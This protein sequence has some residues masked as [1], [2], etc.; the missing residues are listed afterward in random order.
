MIIS[1]FVGGLV[2]AI[3]GRLAGARAG[4]L[5]LLLGLPGA[6]VGYILFQYRPPYWW[7]L[8]YWSFDTWNFTATG[9]GYMIGLLLTGLILWMT[10]GSKS[11][12]Y[13]KEGQ[14]K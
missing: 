12:K 14:E 1:M 13:R 4:T 5:G 7:P 10:H 2:G 9:I 6:F 8:K 3:L 11:I